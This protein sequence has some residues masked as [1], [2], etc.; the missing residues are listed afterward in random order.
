MKQ[1]IEQWM[2]SVKESSATYWVL[3]TW[4]YLVGILALASGVSSLFASY[5][6]GDMPESGDIKDVDWKPIEGFWKW[7][8]R[9][10]GCL[11]GLS[12]AYGCYKVS[13]HVADLRRRQAWKQTEV[14]IPRDL[15]DRAA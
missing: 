9:I 14:R 8:L 15:K 1:R 3:E 7:F 2:K 5:Y 11:T 10:F 6:T 4:F 12:M 13:E